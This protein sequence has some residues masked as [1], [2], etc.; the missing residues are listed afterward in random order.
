LLLL[1]DKSN[2]KSAEQHPKQTAFTPISIRKQNG[3][4]QG[5]TDEAP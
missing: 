4:K 2:T 3:V 1:Q 5:G